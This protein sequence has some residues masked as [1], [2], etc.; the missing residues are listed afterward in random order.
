M[1]GPVSV[2]TPTDIVDRSDEVTIWAESVFR[3]KR[4]SP[5]RTPSFDKILA[6]LERYPTQPATLAQAIFDL[7]W[8]T[9]WNEWG[10]VPRD[11]QDDKERRKVY[12][13]WFSLAPPSEQGLDGMFTAPV[14]A[15]VDGVPLPD[16]R[17]HFN[18]ES[19]DLH[20]LAPKIFTEFHNILFLLPDARD[21]ES[22]CDSLAALSEKLYGILRDEYDWDWPARDKALKALVTF[23]WRGWD[24]DFG[25]D[26]RQRGC[27]AALA[28]Y[29]DAQCRR[30]SSA[31]ISGNTLDFLDKNVGILQ[32]HLEGKG[33]PEEEGLLKEVE[34]IQEADEE[35]TQIRIDRW[36]SEATRKAEALRG[37]A[38]NDLFG[39]SRPKSFKTLGAA[40]RK[41]IDQL[42]SGQDMTGQQFLPV[43]DEEMFRHSSVDS[44]HP[45]DLCRRICDFAQQ[46]S[47]IPTAGHQ[48]GSIDI[49]QVLTFRRGL[50][51]VLVGTSSAILPWHGQDIVTTIIDPEKFTADYPSWLI[52]AFETWRALDFMLSRV[53]VQHTWHGYQGKPRE[54]DPEDRLWLSS[55][56]D[57]W[58]AVDYLQDQ[59]F[60]IMHD[61]RA[62]QDIV[63]QVLSALELLHDHLL[64]FLLG[65]N[66][67]EYRKVST[68]PQTGP[69][70]RLAEEDK[71]TWYA[72]HARSLLVRSMISWSQ[73]KRLA[74]IPSHDSMEDQAE[75]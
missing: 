35:A 38:L 63:P 54:M 64:L 27:E 58:R 8:E 21:Y 71:G 3:I 70:S 17:R 75:K 28:S 39:Q 73:A 52:G 60:K 23:F 16:I 74:V 45:F 19:W 57:A 51:K 55:A 34:E 41:M 22:D 69:P 42:H 68:H 46:H 61:L 31:V 50:A 37:V 6:K 9:L 10:P 72:R 5:E 43:I 49:E 56:F 32:R 13:I 7:G 59:C 14:R 1:S 2:D 65:G 47:L 11:P 53:V 15:Y 26:A 29:V 40:T 62:S 25:S 24:S 18:I 4:A 66:I 30:L 48:D 20:S 44:Q 33:S 67:E 12:E 36:I